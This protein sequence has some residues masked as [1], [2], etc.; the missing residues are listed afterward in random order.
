MWAL[1]TPS[2]AALQGR[3][4]RSTGLEAISTAQNTLFKA[5]FL[6]VAQSSLGVLTRLSAFLL[7]NSWPVLCG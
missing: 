3:V 1:V 6:H 5:G 7:W 4:P 2:T